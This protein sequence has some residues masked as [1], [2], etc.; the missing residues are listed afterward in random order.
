[1]AA[2]PSVYSSDFTLQEALNLFHQKFYLGDG[3]YNDDWFTIKMGLIKIKLPNITSRKKAVRIHDIHHV[4]NGY[5]ATIKG[6][7]EIGMWE[8]VSGCGTYS[9]AW[10]LNLM[11]ISYGLLLYPKAMY[12]AFMLAFPIQ[13]NYYHFGIDDSIYIQRLG[14]IRINILEQTGTSKIVLAKFLFAFLLLVYWTI[15]G[16]IV[17]LLL[18]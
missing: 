10:I 14:D 6:E 8:L 16:G 5:E 3:G 11:S 15:L 7:A 12:Q 9:V 4:I 17:Y 18:N 1:M 13:N 2:N